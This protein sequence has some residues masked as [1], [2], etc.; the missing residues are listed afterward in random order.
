MSR[1]SAALAWT[2]LVGMALTW[3]GLYTHSE[4]SLP[5]TVLLYGPRWVVLLPLILLV[6]AA[7]IFAR[8]ALVPLLVGVW[9]AVMPV[10]GLRVTPA[11]FV[12][13]GASR[14][15]QPNDDSIRVLTL[16][17]QGGRSVQQ[18]VDEM[19][20]AY[21]PS[22]MAFQECGTE[23]ARQLAAHG[24][25][26]R[27]A[28]PAWYFDQY[29]GLCLLSRWPISARDPMTVATTAPGAPA[30]RRGRRVPRGSAPFAIRYTI[31]HPTGPFTLVNLHLETARKGLEGLLGN[32]GLLRDKT[33]LPDLPRT[34]ETTRFHRNADVR[35]RESALTAAW[36]LRDAGLTPL[37]VVG[38]FNMPVESSIYRTYWRSLTNAFEARGNGFGFTKHEGRWLRIRIDHVLVTPRW[39]G[40]EQAWVAPDVG[41]DHRPVVVDLIRTSEP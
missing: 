24:D 26:G 13:D 10:M 21:A 29:Q 5:F 8:R 12:R 25:A 41:S 3:W 28:Q 23:L 35:T 32:E 34:V 9:I 36:S 2:W 40:V 18:H 31:A 37:I 17:A 16:N 11:G 22:I 39:F 1:I 15:T 38:D 6:P 30:T 7:L 19:I 14:S 20:A 4:T 33:G 27:T